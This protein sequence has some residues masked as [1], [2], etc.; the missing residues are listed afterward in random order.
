MDADSVIYLRMLERFVM[1]AVVIIVAA[2]VMIGFWKSIQKIDL[3]GSPEGFGLAGSFV[4]STPV[5]A[6]V[7]LITYA[8]ISLQNPI[9]V[10]SGEITALMAV[11]G[12][13]ARG[14]RSGVTD[15]EFARSEATRQIET[16]NCIARA[17]TTTNRLE[18]DAIA[19]KLALIAPVWDESW[20]SFE[21]FSQ[22]V[23]GFSSDPRNAQALAIFDREY[24]LCEF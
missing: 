2:V 23:R 20:G 24:D 3:K 11:A 4:L 1:T 6:L 8:A 18:D 21:A 15:V 12:A 7:A 14:R 22:S 9:S 5:F 16:L 10:Q 13:D 17:R 19:I